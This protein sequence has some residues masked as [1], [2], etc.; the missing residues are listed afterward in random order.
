MSTAT[1][2]LGISYRTLPDFRISYVW[3]DGWR[4]FREVPVAFMSIVLVESMV[5]WATVWGIGRIPHGASK[6][7]KVIEI[8][9]ILLCMMLLTA[10]AQ[11]LVSVT[12]YRHYQQQRE[13]WAADLRYSVSRA[14]P[15]TMTMLIA[16]VLAGVGLLALVVPCFI[17]ITVYA[18]AIP[19]CAIEG[20]HPIGSL[21]RSAAL[22]K[23][24]GW[25]VFGAIIQFCLVLALLDALID[26]VCISVLGLSQGG[27]AVRVLR[28]LV[29]LVP[30]AVVAVCWATM[31]CQ[32]RGIYEWTVPA[33]E[34]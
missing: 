25:A 17:I 18:V 34:T 14:I 31:Y 4:I 32:L 19:V 22:T 29:T 5:G 10:A 8:L 1:S 3:R 20:V 33:P 15:V 12:V 9:I 6:T 21:A 16:A 13:P 11:A 27:V 2:G 26:G 30:N 7:T 23:G 28:L 24:H